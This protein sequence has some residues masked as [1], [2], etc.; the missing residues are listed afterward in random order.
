MHDDNDKDE[1]M[2]LGSYS[3]ANRLIQVEVPS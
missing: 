1:V 2:Q 3:P